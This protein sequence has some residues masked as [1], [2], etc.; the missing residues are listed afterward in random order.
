MDLFR[1]VLLKVEELPTNTLWS[2]DGIEGYSPEQVGYHL[3]LA[4]DEGFVFARRA[5]DE[6]ENFFVKRLTNAGHEFLEAAKQETLWQKAKEMVLRNAGSLTVEALKLALSHLM[7][8]AA[9]GKSILERV[10]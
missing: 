6:G 5:T 10:V 7:Q 4:M 8:S 3:E 9:Q 1:K 2:C